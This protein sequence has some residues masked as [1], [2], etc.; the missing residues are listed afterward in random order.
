MNETRISLPPIFDFEKAILAKEATA[1]KGYQDWPNIRAA[2]NLWLYNSPTERWPAILRKLDRLRQTE[3]SLLNPNNPLPTIGWEIEIPRKPLWRSRA[4]MYALFFDF[5]GLPRNRINTSIV[6]GDIET[7]PRTFNW[8]FSTT[9]ACS[10]AVANRTLCEL[11]KGGFIPHLEGSSTALDRHRLLDDKLVSL[12]INLGIPSWFPDKSAERDIKSQEDILLLA[13]SFGFAYTS[14]ERF[15][16]RAQTQFVRLKKAEITAKNSS[17]QAQRLELIAFEVGGSNTYRLI[18]EI[19]LVTAAVFGALA[20]RDGSLTAIWGRANSGIHTVYEKYHVLPK[21]IT[22]RYVAA[23]KAQ[24]V[25]LKRDLRR[26]L[27]DT[28]HQVRSTLSQ[29]PNSD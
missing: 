16:T 5:M 9:P 17:P 1:K 26:I 25:D 29:L 24:D 6:P 19:Q 7:Y 4:G 20:E 21:V 2:G 27:T 28:A 10:A 23:N 13:S 12:H 22:A 11:I 3:K 15:S 14:S 8:E 18:E